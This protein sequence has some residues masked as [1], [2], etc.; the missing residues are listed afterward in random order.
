LT[1]PAYGNYQP[2]YADCNC[3]E[4]EPVAPDDTPTRLQQIQ[5]RFDASYYVDN[6]AESAVEDLLAEVSRLREDWQKIHDATAGKRD[7]PFGVPDLCALAEAQR[8]D[9]LSVDD[10]EASKERAEAEVSRLR[11]KLGAIRS[12]LSDLQVDSLSG[13]MLKE[14]LMKLAS[15]TS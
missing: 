14:D 13:A 2:P 9:S 8:S 6:S 11:E 1:C 5:R 10:F 15:E 7:V 3:G 12:G 4:D